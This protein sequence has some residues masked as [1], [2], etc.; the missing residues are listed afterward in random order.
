MPQ[1]PA[2][3]KRLPLALPLGEDP[4]DEEMELVAVGLLEV[5]A[6][7]LA[8]DPEVALPHDDDVQRPIRSLGGLLRHA[9]GLLDAPSMRRRRGQWADTFVDAQRQAKKGAEPRLRALGS[10]LDLLNEVLRAV[11]RSPTDMAELVSLRDQAM[12]MAAA[13]PTGAAQMVKVID[14]RIDDPKPGR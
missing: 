9:V 12:A 2:E 6:E 5:V 7:W 4:S 13:D 1:F 8:D 11:E 3:L 10:S 14:L